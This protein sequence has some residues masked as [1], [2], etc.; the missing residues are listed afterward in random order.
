MTWTA[1]ASSHSL[2]SSSPPPPGHGGETASS[3]ST[4]P[5][6]RFYPVHISYHLCRFS[7]VVLFLDTP[8]ACREPGAFVAPG[9][10]YIPAISFPSPVRL[11]GRSIV[12]LCRHARLFPFASGPHQHLAGFPLLAVHHHLSE[13]ALCRRGS[14]FSFCII[15]SIII[16]VIT[17]IAAGRTLEPCPGDIVAA[18][19]P[20]A[21][22]FCCFQSW[23][24][25][26]ICFL[27]GFLTVDYIGG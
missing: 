7:F 25:A 1:T 5:P 18:G 12:R 2:L 19:G 22:T 14:V 20:G 23:V 11:G 10:I 15:F 13:P 8:R 17:I 24:H 4:Q 9:H 26:A 16:I 6:F 27:F 21:F 3:S